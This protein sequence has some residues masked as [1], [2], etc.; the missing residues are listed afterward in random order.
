MRDNIFLEE[1][2]PEEEWIEGTRRAAEMFGISSSIVRKWSTTGKIEVCP[3][4]L[5]KP[6]NTQNPY[7]INLQSLENVLI[8]K[9]MHPDPWP[10]KSV[11]EIVKPVPVLYSTDHLRRD[12]IGNVGEHLVAYYLSFAG[13][14]VSLVDR[15]GMDHFVRL[16]NGAM[17]ALEVKTASKPYEYSSSRSRS[18]TTAC[19]FATRRL[20]ADWFSFLDLSTNI[21]LFRLQEELSTFKEKETIS[22]KFFTPFY[23]NQSIKRL[24]EYYGAEPDPVMT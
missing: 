3:K 5:S 1:C 22:H 10:D 17:F 24:F 2:G 4:D 9:A 7:L 13:A 12:Q 8:E 11:Q 23:M 16:P 21:V 15:R 19:A 6:V 20:D 14:S 18:T